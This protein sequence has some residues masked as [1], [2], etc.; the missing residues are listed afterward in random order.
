MAAMAS[1]LRWVRRNEDK[2]HRCPQC[3]TIAAWDDPGHAWTVW[4]CE[5][6]RVRWFKGI[7]Y[8]NTPAGIRWRLTMW[9]RNR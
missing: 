5:G 3:H 1:D 7:N 9:W 4:R 8:R 2:P 6:C